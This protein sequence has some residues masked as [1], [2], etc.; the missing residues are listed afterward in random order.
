MNVELAQACFFKEELFQTGVFRDSEKVYI[1]THV[2]TIHSSSRATSYLL[3]TYIQLITARNYISV[4]VLRRNVL[5]HVV[6]K[7]A[8][9]GI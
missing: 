8:S 7:R 4:L 9:T 1:C 5:L 6:S 2:E 3:K